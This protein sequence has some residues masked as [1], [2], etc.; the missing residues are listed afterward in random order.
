MQ[1]RSKLHF[2]F[3]L[4][5]LMVMVAI[6]GILAAIAYPSYINQVRDSRRT[7]AISLLMRAANKQEQYYAIEQTYADSMEKLDLPDN[8]EGEWYNVA[9]T[10][11]SETEYTIKAS[12]QNDQTNDDCGTFSIDETGEKSVGGSESAEAC[13]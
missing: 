12:P 9:V 1:R 2:G 3:T 5:S 8:T 7:E 11:D 13:W 4:I 6:V 10:K